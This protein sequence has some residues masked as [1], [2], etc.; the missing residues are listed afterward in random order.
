M[1]DRAIIDT[2]RF[3]DLP[4]SAKA[5]YFLM[6][7]EADDEGF[8][9]PKKILKLHGGNDDDVKVLIA[10]KFVIPFESGVVVITDW[11]K[12]NWL[13]ARRIKET[14]YTLEKSKL[15]VDE[16]G[17]Y[18]L[19]SN[20]LAFARL[21]ESRIEENRTEEKRVEESR[22]EKKGSYGEFNNVFLLDVEYQK[23]KDKFG[24]KNTNSLIEEL[25]GYMAS[26]KKKY[27]SHYA[28]ILNWFRRKAQNN[29]SQV[30]KNKE[31]VADKL[32]N[33]IK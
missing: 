29:T 27:A 4:M 26:T 28:T 1:F 22:R 23:L 31:S 21:E 24:E 13:D 2:D 32:K 12:N 16:T 19:L 18:T 7:M 14:E 20:G 3:L 33:R 15:S 9:S 10:K 17:Q 30:Y 8:V 25:S 11:H 6:G 5:I